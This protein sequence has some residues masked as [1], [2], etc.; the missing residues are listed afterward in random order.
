MPPRALPE[1]REM[2]A[3]LVAEP[4]PSS[5]DPR[6][7]RG[8]RR[9]VEHLAGWAD[10]LGLRVE[11]LPSAA[12]ND[13]VNLLATFGEGDGGLVLAGHSDTVPWDEGRWRHDPFRV[14][15]V[16]GRLVGLGTSDMKSFF[17]V[18]LAALARIDAS[19]LRAPVMLL[20]TY[21]EE[22]TMGGAR[23]LV[24]AG[25]PR[26]RHAVIGEPTNLVPVRMHKGA[27]METVVL[28]G[29]SGH[30]SD[31]S[32]GRSALEGMHAVIGDL[33]QLREALAAT[34][35]NEAFAVPVPTMNF[36]AIHGGDSP[37]RICGECELRFDLR[38]LPG[39]DV[40]AL[41]AEIRARVARIAEARGL[42]ARFPAQHTGTPPFETS[43]D[44]ELVRAACA[45]TGHEPGVVAFGT[46][47]PYLTQ[48]GAET[49][50]CGP[51][52]IARA[53]QPDESIDLAS[54]APATELLERLVHRFCLPS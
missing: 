9:V 11:L 3:T 4:S 23:A 12:S 18:A 44:A 27:I 41:R 32:L 54:L 29:Q 8:N 53:H 51:G 17:A 31:P 43:A 25:R 14:T 42:S 10:G 40:Q 1:L 16:D 30:S 33:V 39:M 24:A 20:A 37:N 47:A 22:S 2:I 52:D 35:R 46:E 6:F 15:E 34:H 50:V 7:D 13:K 38:A 21:D 48:L 19:R 49:I 26:A 45:L 5:A 28:T 36:G